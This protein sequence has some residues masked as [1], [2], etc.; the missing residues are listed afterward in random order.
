M[1][2]FSNPYTAILL[3]NWTPAPVQKANQVIL[4]KK[5]RPLVGLGTADDDQIQLGIDN[6][7]F[8]EVAG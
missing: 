7:N 3:E 2:A 8:S 4:V 5:K 6:D 1:F